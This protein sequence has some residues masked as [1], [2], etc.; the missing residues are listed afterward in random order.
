MVNL[1]YL[2]IRCSDENQRFSMLQYT[3]ENVQLRGIYPEIKVGPMLC[4]RRAQKL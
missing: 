1:K 2:F 3:I 4:L